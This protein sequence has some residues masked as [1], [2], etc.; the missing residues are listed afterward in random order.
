MTQYE[1]RY[2][3]YARLCRRLDELTRDHSTVSPHAGAMHE[4]MKGLREQIAALATEIDVAPVEVR[5]LI[6]LTGGLLCGQL[7]IVAE[8]QDADAGPLITLRHPGGGEAG[9]FSRDEINALT[10]TRRGKWS[11]NR[12]IPAIGSEVFV[13]M[14]GLSAATV[15]SHE[16]V[17]GW[18]GLIVRFHQPPDWYL[19]QNRGANKP[20]LV[21]G[22]EIK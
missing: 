14:N 8:V 17:E 5:E 18:L 9:R 12:E 16:V 21:Y 1:D 7:F 6:E 13:R 3:D 19:R 11:G 10:F 15:V 4:G 20:G 22:A 2:A